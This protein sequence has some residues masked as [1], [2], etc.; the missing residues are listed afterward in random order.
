MSQRWIATAVDVATPGGWVVVS[1]R[2]GFWVDS[3][4]FLFPREW[5]KRQQ[6]RSLSEQGL[7]LFDGQ[8]VYLLELLEEPD[9]PGAY[10]QSLRPF[11]AQVDVDSFK[12]L[13]YAAQIATW[14]RNHRFCG[15]CGQAMVPVVG[16]R[17]VRCAACEISHYPQLSPSM[18]VLVTRGEQIL[19]ARS[20]HFVSGMYSTLAGFVEPGESVEQCVQREVFE[21][22]GL[23][24]RNPRY[25]ASQNWPFPHSL[26]LGYHV[27]YESG[28]ITPQPEEIE[29]A[30]WFDLNDLPAMPPTRAISRYLIDLYCAQRLGLP[31]PVLPS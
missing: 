31:E 26:M 30:R 18:I 27:E 20:A 14:Q 3:N 21:E 28:E 12:L 7:G 16:Q 13:G 6:L 1:S 17:C 23:K 5:F 25:I 29:D 9:M 15:G 19:L 8:P 4:G 10:W 24:V 22:V 2:Q 11:M